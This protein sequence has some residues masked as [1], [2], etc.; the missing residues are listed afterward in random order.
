MYQYVGKD[1]DGNALYDK[2]A[3]L[4]TLTATGT[5]KLHGT[6][7]GVGFGTNVD[8]DMEMWY[9]SRKNI[10][11]PEKDNAGFAFFADARK[12]QFKNIALNV[13]NILDV[14]IADIVIYGEF[15][16][17]NIQKG[18][19]ITGLDKMF[20]IF[21]V[22]ILGG[23]EESNSWLTPAQVA[24]IFVGDYND[25]RIYNIYDFPTYTMRI[26]L[27]KPDMSS[28]DMI[29]ITE[30][31]EAECP[32]A[33]AL[34]AEGELIGEGVVWI[35]AHND[36]LTRFKVKGE[37]HSTSKVKKL[38]SVDVEKMNNISEFVEYACTENRLE[39]GVEYIFIQNGEEPSMKKMGDYIRWVVNDIIAEE[40]DTMVGSNIEPKDIGKGVA[41]TARKF[42]MNKYG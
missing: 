40:T 42:F 13:C 41:D 4:P 24:E 36:T 37:K 14:D 11:T 8:G 31:V 19:G 6:N 7:A 15:C 2:T 3:T 22:K 27:N 32:V 30:A 28:N 5:I 20:V 34:G 10:I 21:G 23:D 9:Q 25:D 18:V 16:G 17:G 12:I 33:K 35:I 39:Q 38:A 29:A 26:D 1:G